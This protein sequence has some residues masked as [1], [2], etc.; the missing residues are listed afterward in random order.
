MKK[1]RKFYRGAVNHVYQRTIDGVQL[2]YCIEDCLV[3]YTIFAVCSKNDEVVPLELCLMHNHTHALIQCETVQ[4][5]S[6][7]VDHYT[8]WYVQEYNSFIG[9]RGKLFKKN[10]GSAP[11][12]DDKRLRSAIIYIGNNPVEKNFCSSARDYRW[13]FLAYKDNGSPF[14]EKLVKRNSSY[15]L[16]KALKEVD[17][18]VSLNLP[19]KYRQ[20]IRM[21]RKLNENEFEQLVDYIITAY[22]PFDYNNLSSHFKSYDSMLLAMDSTTGDDYDIKESRDRFSIMSFREM[23]T[24]FLRRMPMYEIRKVTAFSLEDKMVLYKELLEN[25]SATGKQIC[26]FLHIHTEKDSPDSG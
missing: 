25:T 8:S 9:R 4:K 14:S 3:F 26:N 7:F 22:L 5:L 17:S 1:K 10:F 18:M 20:L 15:E 16:K 21:T 24:Y 13:N 12:W 11:K 19:I 6:R 23:R 2:F